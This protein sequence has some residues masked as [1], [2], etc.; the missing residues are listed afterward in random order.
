MQ[1]AFLKNHKLNET[2]DHIF[3]LPV[4]ISESPIDLIII[5]LLMENQV[6]TTMMIKLT[7]IILKDVV[8]K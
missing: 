5:Y 6:L 4:H 3:L 1:F 8:F 7:L 2:T